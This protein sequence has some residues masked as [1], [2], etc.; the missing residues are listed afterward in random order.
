MAVDDIVT[1]PNLSAVLD[2][3]R[4]TRLQ[5]LALVD[6]I[7]A[8]GP[9]ENASTESQLEISKQQKLLITNLAQLRGLHRAAFF[10]ARQTKSQTSEARQEVDR[11][12]LQLQN[13]YYEQRHLQGEIA[14]CESYD[15][16]YQQLPLIP[17]EEFLTLH[18][19]HADDDENA[20]MI[21]RIEHER[22]EREALEQKRMELL[23]RKQKLIA[24]NKKRKD[25]LANLDKELEK[26]IDA[27][28]P[29]QKLFDKN[30]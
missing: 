18:P 23:R 15:H 21:A 7:A 16:T 4:D 11:L 28:K 19:E 22:T 1:D 27:A 24:D 29:I 8:T 2:T 13:L 25:D 30:I 9:I 3:S 14:A 5:A 17:V 26:F 20:L 10:G 12:H 6:L